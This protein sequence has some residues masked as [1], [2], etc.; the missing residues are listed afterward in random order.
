MLSNKEFNISAGHVFCGTF[1]AVLNVSWY[2]PDVT[3]I[4]QML[5]SFE[6]MFRPPGKYV[7]LKLFLKWFTSRSAE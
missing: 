3:N 7:L 6:L 2:Y 5:Q 4:K 1:L